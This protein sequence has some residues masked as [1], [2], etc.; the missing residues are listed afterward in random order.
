MENDEKSTFRVPAEKLISMVEGAKRDEKS[1][2]EEIYET[3]EGYL[4]RYFGKKVPAY[5]IP[6]RIQ[7]TFVNVYKDIGKLKKPVAFTTWTRT[8]A[9]REIYH[10]YKEKELLQEREEKAKKKAEKEKVRKEKRMAGIDLSK[11]DMREAVNTL[12]AKQK[13]AVL[14]REKGY[15]VREIAEIQD[16][17][18]GTV[19]SRLNYARIKISEY[20][21]KQTAERSTTKEPS[22]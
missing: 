14:L 21:K 1:A 2:K 7:N 3:Y 9:R 20:I 5:D 15:K 13:E 6:K 16:V 10:Y 22:I 8:I 19:K 12:P 18:E 4:L 11:V 17:S